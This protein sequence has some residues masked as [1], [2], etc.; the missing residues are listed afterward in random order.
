MRTT[1]QDD[2][3]RRVLRRTERSGR[4]A[5]LGVDGGR[6][7]AGDLNHEVRAGQCA[8]AGFARGE[9]RGNIMLLI[10]CGNEPTIGHIFRHRTTRPTPLSDT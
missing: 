8:E 10:M 5:A 2:R 9:Q 6:R 1:L 3:G 7:L 4:G